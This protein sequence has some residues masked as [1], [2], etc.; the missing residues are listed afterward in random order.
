MELHRVRDADRSKV[1][2]IIGVPRAVSGVQEAFQRTV[3]SSGN[4]TMKYRT[5]RP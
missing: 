3:P 5:D 4:G 2:I 1:N